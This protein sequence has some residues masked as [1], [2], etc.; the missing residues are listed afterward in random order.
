MSN[1]GAYYRLAFKMMA[2][3]TGT[4]AVPAVLAALIGKFLDARYETAPRFVLILLLFAL[5]SSGA[6]L[7]KKA[8]AYRD[9]FESIS[10]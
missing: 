6:M 8:R 1:D 5:L 10:K 4:I 2:N 3:L 7:V 9:E